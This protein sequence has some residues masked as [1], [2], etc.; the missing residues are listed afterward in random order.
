MSALRH[1]DG[2]RIDLDAAVIM[3]DH[4]HAIFRITDG[5][6]LGQILHSVKSFSSNEIN[7]L[8]SRSGPLWLD[9]SFDHII[10]HGNEWEEKAEYVRQN[11]VKKGLAERPEVYHWL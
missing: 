7:K 3:P 4:V 5:S 1:W 9:E 2:Q 8:L 11:P 10:R 6:T